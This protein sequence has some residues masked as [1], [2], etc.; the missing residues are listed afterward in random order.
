MLVLN[1]RWRTQ[2]PGSDM[3]AVE[4]N[5]AERSRGPSLT[6]SSRVLGSA[7]AYHSANFILDITA[8]EEDIANVPSKRCNVA[9]S[10]AVYL[11]NV[12]AHPS[13]L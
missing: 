3:P 10:N 7:G 5:I 6:I 9:R 12:K 11:D 1:A 13:G 8:N 2:W 4:L